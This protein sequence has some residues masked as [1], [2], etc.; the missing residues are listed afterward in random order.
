MSLINEDNHLTDALD[1]ALSRSSEFLD[2]AMM[3]INQLSPNS[4]ANCGVVLASL[5]ASQSSVFVGQYYSTALI[6]EL[7]AI[8]DRLLALE[9][10]KEKLEDV[11]ESLDFI[12]SESGH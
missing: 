9:G 4:A 6:F 2:N 10:I 7:E 3:V 5:I 11:A 1:I 12:A 8:K